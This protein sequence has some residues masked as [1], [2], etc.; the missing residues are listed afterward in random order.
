MGKHLDILLM[1][2]FVT[3]INFLDISA[4]SYTIV[5]IEEAFHLTDAHIGYI[6]AGFGVGYLLTI[7]FSGFLVDRFGSIKVWAISALLWSLI[8]MATSLARDFS[9]F[10]ILRILLGAVES[11]HFPSLV[12]TIADWLEPASRGRSF[13]IALLGIPISFIIGGPFLT[14]LIRIYTWKGMYVI[15]GIFG[16]IWSVSWIFIFWDK[17]NPHLSASPFPPT[18]NRPTLLR[19]FSQSP[20][21]LSLCAL[22]FTFAYLLF[23]AINWFPYYLQKIYSVE[24]GDAGFLGIIP[25]LSAALFLIAGGIASDFLLKKTRSLRIARSYQ[26]ILGFFLAAI[27]FLLLGFSQELGF[28]IFL[29]SLALGAI[30]L[31][32]T[33]L[34]VINIDLFPRHCSFAIGVT[35]LFASLALILSPAIT[36]KLVSITGDFQW[37]I[38]VSAAVSFA[39]GCIAY[40]FLKPEGRLE[41]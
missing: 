10:L 20:T 1:I 37:A 15:L 7:T 35:I 5:P 8:T 14:S 12:R 23:F 9:S 28:S 27:C 13:A 33:P 32:Q 21:F 2:L 26:S 25:W 24:P 3:V 40:F 34:F 36:G 16:L 41:V 4:L 18:M 31:F 6:S 39:A 11:A 19:I 29:F 30:F 38:H 17:K 22:N